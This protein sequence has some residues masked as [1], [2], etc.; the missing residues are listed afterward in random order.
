METLANMPVTGPLLSLGT[1][2]SYNIGIQAV[3][4]LQATKM[5][6][7]G[8]IAMVGRSSFACFQSAC[9]R[10][11]GDQDGSKHHNTTNILTF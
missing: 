1:P 7:L 2:L 9:D 3:V 8:E 5:L 4:K 6:S 11:K 10:K